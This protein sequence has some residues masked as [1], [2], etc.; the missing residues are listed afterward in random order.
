MNYIIK[1]MIDTI[2]GFYD[3]YYLKKLSTQFEI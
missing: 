1:A 2:K 3:Y